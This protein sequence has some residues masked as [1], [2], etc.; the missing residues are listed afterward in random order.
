MAPISLQSEPD[1]R[2]SISA[3]P[4]RYGPSPLWVA[5]LVG[6]FCVGIFGTAAV[7]HRQLPF[8]PIATVKGKVGWFVEHGDQY[9][10]LFV[11]S[12]RTNCHIIPELF[13]RLMAQAGMPTHSFNLGLNGMRP[14]EDTFV[15]E[16]ALS[17]RRAP[18]KLVVAELNE[19]HV[20][21]NDDEAH[22]TSRAVYWHDWKRFMAVSRAV[23]EMKVEGRRKLSPMGIL[24]KLDA[25]RYN[26]NLY[27]SRTLSAGRGL[28]CL[29]A[30]LATTEQTFLGDVGSR[31]DGYLRYDTPLQTINDA[32]WDVLK[33]RLAKGAK[34]PVRFN[35]GTKASQ[36]ELQEKQ[37]LVESF[38]G[39]MVT[40][41]PPLPSGNVFTLNPARQP[42]VD[43]FDFADPGLYPEL[44][45]RE[46]R[47]DSGHLNQQGAEI[48]TR[49]LVKKIVA[50]KQV[51][52]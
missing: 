4:R 12:S 48:F 32:E 25:L 36:L 27:L 19:I 50:E 44:F 43:C 3:K 22:G 30:R 20:Y 39:R 51:W 46:N 47:F 37:R 8:P 6:L 49:L 15:L 23:L 24:W 9:D 1:Q 28:D 5:F 2:Q 17:K 40:F 52:K 45:Q 26:L 29:E 41:V 31:F 18:L 38:G 13:D 21:T 16:T 14:P 33:S 11:G 7:I 10:T 34:K 35:Y 42:D